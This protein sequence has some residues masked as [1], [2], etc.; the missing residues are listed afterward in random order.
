MKHNKKNEIKE[1]NEIKK[2]HPAT[3][4]DG[5]KESKE[6]QI[7]DAI[8]PYEGVLPK[9][10]KFG[11]IEGRL[12]H[13]QIVGFNVL[14]YSAYLDLLKD[15]YQTKFKIPIKEF[16]NLAKLD[17]HDYYSHLFYKK[18]EKQKSLETLLKELIGANYRCEWRKDGK[19]YR[20]LNAS[21][22]SEFEMDKETKMIKFAFPPFFRDNLLVKGDFYFLYIPV[23]GELRGSYAPLL[24]EQILQRRG[25]SE[26]RIEAKELREIL[27]VESNEYKDT[28]DFHRW[29][30]YPAIRIINEITEMNLKVYKLKKGKKIIGYRFTWDNDAFE[31]IY[32]KYNIP[33]PIISQEIPS[34]DLGN[35]LEPQSPKIISK[36]A[37]I[38]ELE[39]S[40]EIE[41][42]LKLLP[43]DLRDEQIIKHWLEKSEYQ[44]VKDAI[45]CAIENKAKNIIA[46]VNTL[47]E[48]PEKNLFE[49]RVKQVEKKREGLLKQAKEL[50]LQMEQEEK[51][52]LIDKW[53]S[54]ICKEELEKMTE[55]E[56][57]ELQKQAEENLY[58][59]QIFNQTIKENKGNISPTIKKISLELEMKKIIKDRLIKQGIKPP[60]DIEELEEE[61]EER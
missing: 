56:K 1:K 10:R 53:W 33:K 22:L 31:K 16:C 14:L 21:L 45:L 23:L 55:E 4:Q 7:P 35:E 9:N 58:Q 15:P 2:G 49:F 42:L 11:R 59:K 38:N 37:N 41:P 3:Q 57:I 44:D 25:L 8:I 17:Y 34:E 43:Q 36:D 52:A 26:W 50:K 18:G 19:V 5:Q 46:Y 32:R 13:N 60:E 54:R 27:G 28:L 39:P 61:V 20:V 48:D 6:K 30:L 29:V 24:Y 47:L 12:E 51:E 40:S